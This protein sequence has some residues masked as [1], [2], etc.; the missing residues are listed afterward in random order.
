MSMYNT[1][2]F[3]RLKNMRISGIDAYGRDGSLGFF[4]L[5]VLGVLGRSKSTYPS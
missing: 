3:R 1:M 5:L 4:F 2:E